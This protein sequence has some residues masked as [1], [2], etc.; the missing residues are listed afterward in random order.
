[1]NTPASKTPRDSAVETRYL[2]MPQHANDAGI[3][4]G[5]TLMAWIDMVAAMVAQRHC[6]GRVVTA[7]IDRLSF[8]APCHIGDQVVLRASANYVGH[9]SMEVGVQ[10]SRECPCSGLTVRTTAAYLTFV[11]LD[12]RERPVAIAA[13]RPE[14]PDELRR[15]E[16]ARLRVVARKELLQKLQPR[17]ESPER[18]S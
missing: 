9:T 14:T 18:P 5:G 17:A 2:I 6:G 8:L 4:F 16:N 15:W 7:S 11:A 3:L 1:M 13:L 10:V 12:P